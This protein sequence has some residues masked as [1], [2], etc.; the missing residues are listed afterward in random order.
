M[1]LRLRDAATDIN[2]RSG[3]RDP[4]RLEWVHMSAFALFSDVHAQIPERDKRM[5][6]GRKVGLISRL[7]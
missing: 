1:A 3:V 4:H 7:F 6:G 2:R 5:V